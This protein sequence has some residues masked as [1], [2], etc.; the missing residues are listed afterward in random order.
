VGHDAAA[1]GIDRQHALERKRVVQPLVVGEHRSVVL[2]GDRWLVVECGEQFGRLFLGRDGVFV[3]RR[4]FVFWWRRLL[5]W[6]RLVRWWRIVGRRRVKWR[7]G[8]LRG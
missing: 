6:G 8:Q 2:D 4:R 5:G 1:A 7:R 3:R